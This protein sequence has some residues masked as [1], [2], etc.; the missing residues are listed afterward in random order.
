MH[1][2]NM[3]SLSSLREANSDYAGMKLNAVRPLIVCWV[4]TALQDQDEFAQRRV[5]IV[6]EQLLALIE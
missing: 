5:V 1:E 4:F 3:M 6:I 2:L